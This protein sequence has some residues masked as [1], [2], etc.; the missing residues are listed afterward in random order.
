MGFLSANYVRCKVK[1]N[2]SALKSIGLPFS[3]QIWNSLHS[4]LCLVK[5]WSNTLVGIKFIKETG[6]SI[7]LKVY[8]ISVSL[9]LSLTPYITLQWI[10]VVLKPI[11]SKIV[12]DVHSPALYNIFLKRL[13]SKRRLSSLHQS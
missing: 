13:L 1:L 11:I 2:T 9:P 4:I 12:W 6:G 10:L 7:R 8:S 5:F 3:S